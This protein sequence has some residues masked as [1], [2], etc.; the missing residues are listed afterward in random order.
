MQPLHVRLSAC[1]FP[2][3]RS[4]YLQVEPS[5]LGYVDSYWNYAGPAYMSGSG[6]TDGPEEI[7]FSLTRRG[8][9]KKY[10][11]VMTG[12]DALLYT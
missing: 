1:P 2:H 3:T 5:A 11:Q 7:H 8:K 6:R 4:T 12:A 10:G 9:K